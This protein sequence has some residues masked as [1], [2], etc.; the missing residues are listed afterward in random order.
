[1]NDMTRRNAFRLFGAALLGGVVATS[2]EAEAQ[3][4]YDPYDRPPPRRRPPPPPPGYGPPPPPPGYGP[5]PWRR[6]CW[7]RETPWGPRKVC[8]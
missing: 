2:G 1:M 3:P 4:Y 6:R 8:R 7:W 5:P